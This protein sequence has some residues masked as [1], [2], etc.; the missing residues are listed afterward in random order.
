MNRR[1]MLGLM[2]G[3]VPLAASWKTWAQEPGSYP[4]KPIRLVVP[5]PAGGAADN[6]ARPLAQA[7]PR[8]RCRG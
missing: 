5:F 2:A 6:L 8:G 3:G 4:E 1:K 7:L